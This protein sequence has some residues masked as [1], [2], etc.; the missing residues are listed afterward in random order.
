VKLVKIVLAGAALII[1]FM[2]IGRAH[3]DLREFDPDE[4]APDEVAVFDA[5]GASVEVVKDARAAGR[6]P[7]CYVQG[8]DVQRAMNACRAKGFDLYVTA[9][10]E[11]AAGSA[12]S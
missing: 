1:L 12:G 6:T 3:P 7:V 8:P 10:P 9:S 5:I 4:Y 11:A 2:L